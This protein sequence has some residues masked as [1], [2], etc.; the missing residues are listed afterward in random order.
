M[1]LR[2]TV[3]S[4]LVLL[5]AHAS[6]W[7]TTDLM[8]ELPLS[9]RFAC[10]ICHDTAAPVLADLNVFGIAFQQNGSQ[11]N[12]ELAAKSSDADGCSNGFELGDEDGDGTLDDANLE[13]ERHNPGADDCELQ[14][15]KKAWGEL[16]RLFR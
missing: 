15:S 8:Q 12:A 1:V 2:A 9:S 5:G 16:K 14:L 13:T 7:A 3:C 11:W 6:A 10:L 4:L